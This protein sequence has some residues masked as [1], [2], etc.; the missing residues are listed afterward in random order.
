VKQS[1][2]YNLMGSWCGEERMVAAVEVACL[3]L[4]LGEWW[5][6]GTGSSW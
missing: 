6:A 2:G 5:L 4:A 3:G 1:T